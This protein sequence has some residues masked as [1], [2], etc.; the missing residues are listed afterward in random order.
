MVDAQTDEA[1]AAPPVTVIMRSK[2]ADWVIGDALRSLFAQSYR[3]FELD[4][5]DSGSTDRTL[6][7]ISEFPARL[8]HI[9]AEDYYPGPVLNDAA[10]RARGQLLVF[11]NSDSVL[12]SKHSLAHLVEAFSAPQVQA[13]FGRQVARPEAEPWVRREY[14]L[15]FPERGAAPPWITM[16]MPLAAMRRSAWRER[17][18]YRRAW[19]SE[20]SEWGHWARRRGWT[21]RYVPEA[22]TMHSHNYNLRQ[23]YGRQFIEGEAD[24][25]IFR[26]P[27][28]ALQC[29][30]Q[31]V[32][33]ALRDI[34][35]YLRARDL[36]GLMTVPV[37]RSVHQW[38]YWRGRR[39]GE[40]RLTTG[41]RDASVGQRAVLSRYDDGR[42]TGAAS[43]GAT[44][45]SESGDLQ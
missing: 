6:D 27:M 41:D 45:L 32:G 33:A 20:D 28:S 40:R 23:L 36:R 44:G 16:S 13:A 35:W 17:P 30:A 29:V 21:V 31:G 4:I 26:E 14:L 12:Q 25:F 8:F 9:K 22:V 7:I 5:V 42:A 3:D 10:A 37:R 24:A 38:G 43:A 18:F 34:P 39:L 11:Q 2:D 19:G 15:N 1:R